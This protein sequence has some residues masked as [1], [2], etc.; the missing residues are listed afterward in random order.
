M[1][2][3]NDLKRIFFGAKSITKGAATRTY[4]YSKEKSEHL[5]DVTEDFVIDKKNQFDDKFDEIKTQAS[6]KGSDVIENIKEKTNEIIDDITESEAYKKTKETVEKAGDVILDTGESFI[7]KSK[8][9]IDGPGKAVAEKFKDASEDIGETL[10]AGGKTIYD[11]ASEITKDLGAKLDKTI[12]KSE[13]FAKKENLNK[14]NTEFANTPF[15]VKDSE[16]TDK[17]DFFDKADK[18]AS[19]EYSENPKPRIL[20]DKI[21]SKKENSDID[22]FIDRDK[23]GNPLIDEA[24]IIEEKD[25]IKSDEKKKN[26]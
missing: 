17:D 18:F 21:I 7:E 20:K 24:E 10:L 16:L 1:G 14:N 12:E 23:D 2:L 4:D 11:K 3:L 15:E 19:G 9:F 25:K 6:K 22:G 8:D 13:E 5:L 26:K